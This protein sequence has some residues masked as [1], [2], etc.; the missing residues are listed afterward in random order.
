LRLPLDGGVEVARPVTELFAVEAAR[1][2]RRRQQRLEV[3]A[4]GGRRRVL[5]GHH[6]ALLGEPQ[7][8]PY[9]SGRLGED[10]LIGGP[11]TAAD[12]ATTAMKDLHRDTAFADS[13]RLPCG[14]ARSFR[15]APGRAACDSRAAA[16]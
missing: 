1:L 13:S 8:T 10:R 7:R 14:P 6:L 4:G 5:G 15:D 9:R 3:P 12:R 2:E 11:A 16:K